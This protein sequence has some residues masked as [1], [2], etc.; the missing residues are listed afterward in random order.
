[1]TIFRK[2]KGEI[3]ISQIKEEM[4]I[5]PLFE[6]I[7]PGKFHLSRHHRQVGNQWAKENSFMKDSQGHSEKVEKGNSKIEI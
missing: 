4:F 1:M 6:Q 5:S 3:N 2:N 7:K